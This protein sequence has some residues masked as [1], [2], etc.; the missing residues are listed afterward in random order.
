MY[1]APTSCYGL[2]M[3]SPR[4]LALLL[5]FASFTAGMAS[6]IASVLAR[7]VLGGQRRLSAEAQALGDAVRAVEVPGLGLNALTRCSRWTVA[8]ST[9]SVDKPPSETA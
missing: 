3:M 5:A 8:S 1:L 9:R 4:V 6:S 7:G 2:A